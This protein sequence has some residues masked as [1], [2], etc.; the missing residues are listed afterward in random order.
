MRPLCRQQQM[1]VQSLALL[2]VEPSEY[3][4]AYLGQS[5]A[6]LR[7]SGRHIQ[8]FSARFSKR[9]MNLRH[10]ESQRTNQGVG[11]SNLSRACQL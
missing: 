3:F 1:R 7:L 4:A 5:V 6:C 9:F 8:R 11:S 2:V 10:C